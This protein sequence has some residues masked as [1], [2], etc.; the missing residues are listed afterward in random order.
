MQEKIDYEAISV[1]LLEITDR[2]KLIEKIFPI[3]EEPLLKHFAA[4]A[5]H[6]ALFSKEIYEHSSKG[7]ISVESELM[8]RFLD[9]C[10]CKGLIKN[11]NTQI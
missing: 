2:I 6:L 9:E 10:G 4:A 11:D 5:I 1:L 3:T 8:Q 7:S